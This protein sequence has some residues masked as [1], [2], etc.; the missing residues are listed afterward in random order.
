SA[1]SR[2]IMHSCL[3]SAK[4]VRE[5][6]QETKL[7]IASVYRYVKRLVDAE[8]LVVERSAITEDGKPFDLYRCRIRTGRIDFSPAGSKITW[9]Y[10]MPLEDKLLHIWDHFGAQ[11]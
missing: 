4:S 5:I 10:N 9:E 7:A 8:I 3:S 2:A 1:T 6:T 11:A